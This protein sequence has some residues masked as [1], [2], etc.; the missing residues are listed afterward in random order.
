MLQLDIQCSWR[1]AYVPETC[2][3]KNT[4]IKLPSCIK[5]TFHFISWGRCT[6][7]QPSRFYSVLKW[8]ELNKKFALK[9]A[10]YRLLWE[11]CSI[12]PI[13]WESMKYESLLIKFYNTKCKVSL[14][15]ENTSRSFGPFKT[16]ILHGLVFLL[17]LWKIPSKVTFTYL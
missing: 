17:F 9:N 8:T 5:L 2:Q 14:D 12:F 15:T 1:W 4:S 3:A 6:V 11:I 10:V 16:W 13:P 7:K